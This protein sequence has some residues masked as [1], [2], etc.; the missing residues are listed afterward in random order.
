MKKILFIIPLIL[1]IGFSCV[2]NVIPDGYT[3]L[4]Q[5]QEFYI[6]KDEFTGSSF[7][8]HKSTFPPSVTNVIN[9]GFFQLYIVQKDNLM[10]LRVKWDYNSTDWIFF[11]TIYMMGNNGDKIVW[12]NIKIYDKETHNDANIVIETVDF[13]LTFEQIEKIE[14]ILSSPLVKCRFSG[15][16]NEDKVLKDLDRLGALATVKLYKTMK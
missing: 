8:K 5:G 15:K 9:M 13:L 14:K 12:E 7:I 1:I 4:N 3:L 6:K 16:T 10:I 11:D 2:P